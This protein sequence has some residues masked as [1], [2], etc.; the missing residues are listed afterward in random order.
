MD[1][2]FNFQEWLYI[3]V[4]VRK[5]SFSKHPAI[6]ASVHYRGSLLYTAKE[7]T[8]SGLL[9]ENI[10][11]EDLFVIALA[12]LST[13]FCAFRFVYEDYPDHLEMD[14]CNL[15][16]FPLKYSKFPVGSSFQVIKKLVDRNANFYYVIKNS[17]E[18]MVIG[19]ERELRFFPEI[20]KSYSS[21][22][23]WDDSDGR[24]SK[25]LL[26]KSFRI[27][28]TGKYDEEHALLEI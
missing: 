24:S 3:K 16:V 11:N 10:C 2:Y 25:K 14:D 4:S 8:Y 7:S 26:G 27:L 13:V 18:G 17:V 5:P 12:T 15:P 9:Y 6:S 21:P 28:K 20:V 19:S 1:Y 22:L 23:T